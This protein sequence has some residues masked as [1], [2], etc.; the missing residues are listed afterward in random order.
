MEFFSPNSAEKLSIYFLNYICNYK[1]KY[2]NY[3]AK[4]ANGRKFKFFIT[5][6]PKII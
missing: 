3:Q 6:I 4:A 5:L 2:D 1:L